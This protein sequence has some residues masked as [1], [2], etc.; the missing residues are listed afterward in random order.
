[1]AGELNSITLSVLFLTSFILCHQ[2]RLEA[3]PQINTTFR[4]HPARGH[5]ER[6][7]TKE[8]SAGDEWEVKTDI[9]DNS[10]PEAYRPQ[11]ATI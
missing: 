1:M 7:R 8:A 10:D 5:H 4:S 3:P 2:V 6:V 9:S 11:Y